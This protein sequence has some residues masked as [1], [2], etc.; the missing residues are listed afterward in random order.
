[1]GLSVTDSGMGFDFAQMIVDLKTHPSACNAIATKC[2]IFIS[3]F[4]LTFRDGMAKLTQHKPH[5]PIPLQS[6]D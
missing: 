3:S 4:G 5:F 2:G 6:G 1:V